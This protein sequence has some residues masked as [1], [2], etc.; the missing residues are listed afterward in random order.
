MI[1]LGEEQVHDILEFKELVR[2]INKELKSKKIYDCEYMLINNSVEDIFHVL[3]DNSEYYNFIKDDAFGKSSFKNYLEQYFII[4]KRYYDTL[5]IKEGKSDRIADKYYQKITEPTV[6]QYP[7]SNIGMIP[8]EVE[9]TLRLMKEAVQAYYK[10]YH[11]KELIAELSTGDANKSEYLTFQ[12]KVQNLLHLLGVSRTQ[13]LNNPDF[14][15]LTGGKVIK[16][17]DILEWILQDIDGNQDLLQFQEDIIKRIVNTK[18][19]AT[20]I[21]QFSPEVTTQLFNYYKIRSKSNTFL[22]YGP[23][24]KVSLVAK[25]ANGKT[26]SKN[27][28]STSAMITRTESFRK[29]PWAYFGRAERDNNSYIETLQIDSSEHKKELFK[30][31]RPAIIKEVKIVGE[32]GEEGGKIF[33]E[34]E[35]FNLFVQAYEDFSTVM[36]F[37][38]LISYFNGLQEKYENWLGKSR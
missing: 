18:E 7:K 21:K 2:L 26:L 24:E 32:E 25:L 22:K 23:F 14:Q 35:Q 16:S 30:G 20:T 33:S 5:L 19:F 10:V 11:N 38:D 4:V 37:Q 28:N 34:E 17:E 36:D 27:S 13:L 8:Q 9:R 12:I 6:K 31:S 15:K 1:M 29:Y 3:E